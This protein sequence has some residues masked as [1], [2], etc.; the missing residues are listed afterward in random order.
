MFHAKEG[1]FFERNKDGSVHIVKTI[2][3]KFESEIENEV[4]IDSDMWASIVSS[5]SVGGETYDKW[6]QV[7][8][9]HNGK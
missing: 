7:R 6:I 9:F 3:P 5:V 1:W 4:V 2:E 8:K